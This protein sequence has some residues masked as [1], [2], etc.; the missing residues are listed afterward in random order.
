MAFGGARV[1]ETIEQLIQQQAAERQTGATRGAK[2]KW[3]LPSRHEGFLL[4]QLCAGVER[5]WWTEFSPEEAQEH[6]GGYL[7]W[8]YFGVAQQKSDGS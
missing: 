3:K 8:L 1:Q 6:L 2:G 5:G 4:M 7:A